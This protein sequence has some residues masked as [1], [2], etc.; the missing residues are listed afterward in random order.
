MTVRMLASILISTVAWSAPSFAQI[1]D[2]AVRILVLNDQSGPNADTGGPGS[3]VAAKLAIEEFNGKVA[4]APIEIFVADHQNKPDM[5]SGIV[6]RYIDEKGIDAIVDVPVSSVALAVAGIAKDRDKA[7]LLANVGSP[8]LTSGSCAPT[9]VNWT[10]DTHMLAVGTAQGALDRGFKKWF[11]VTADYAFGKQLQADATSI[12]EAGGGTV[13]GSVRHPAYAGT[14]FSSYLLHAMNSSAD[15]IALANGAEDTI[16]SIKQAAE[17]NLTKDKNLAALLLYITD[18]HAIGLKVGQGLLLT[19]SFYW[20]QTPEARAWSL[21]YAER[22]GG[23]RPTMAQAGVYASVLHYLKAVQAAGTDQG[24]AAVDA[25]KAMPTD[26]PLFGKGTI[27][28]DGRK[29]HD[30]WVYQVKTPEESKEPW[31]YYK[32][33]ARIPAEKAFGPMRPECDFKKK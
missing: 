26:D 14:D 23:K 9:T 10:F 17:F 4:G 11:F 7:L 2:G 33:I 6:R 16:N 28:A 32:P 31:D 27:R 29:M 21:R 13:V 1:S 19:E 8:E 18:V 22:M 24:R 25:M 12:V 3:V 5:A 30:A 15:I 20:N